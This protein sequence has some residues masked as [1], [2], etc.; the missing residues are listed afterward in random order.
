MKLNL[1]QNPKD[2]ALE[3]V[4]NLSF[5]DAYFK[6]L[7]TLACISSSAKIYKEIYGLPKRSDW[8]KPESIPYWVQWDLGRE[9]IT[10]L[11]Q[12]CRQQ[13]VQPEQSQFW[14]LLDESYQSIYKEKYEFEREVQVAPED[15]ETLCSAITND[16]IALIGGFKLSPK[17]VDEATGH[18]GEEVFWRKWQLESESGICKEIHT[19]NFSLAKEVFET[20]NNRCVLDPEFGEKS[21][22]LEWY[23]RSVYDAK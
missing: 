14:P 10:I 21:R 15:F 19:D 6:I 2:R 13:N 9:L 7:L 3:L 8:L 23:S 1:E 11:V 22:K 4:G 20:V 18:Y 17:E 5:D 12:R 16:N